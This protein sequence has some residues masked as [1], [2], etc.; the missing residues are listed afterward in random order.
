MSQFGNVNVGS[1]K[2]ISSIIHLLLEE[3]KP[4]V[5][6]LQFIH[7]VRQEQLVFAPYDSQ[8]AARSIGIAFVFM[9]VVRS[10]SLSRSVLFNFLV[11]LPDFHK[12]YSGDA[13]S[14]ASM[15][16]RN[17]STS[18]DLVQDFGH[19]HLRIIFFIQVMFTGHC[20]CYLH[21][22]NHI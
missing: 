10:I 1:D 16:S 6:H 17:G 14:S 19:N 20:V 15:K 4:L 13:C 18:F 9:M 3:D 11:G 12:H 2:V 8:T 22:P 5:Q 21:G 7:Q